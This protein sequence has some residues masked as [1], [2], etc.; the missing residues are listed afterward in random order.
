[1]LKMVGVITGLDSLAVNIGFGYISF[2]AVVRDQKMR[3]RMQL[4]QNAE[5]VWKHF[6]NDNNSVQKKM[7]GKKITIL[8]ED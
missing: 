7:S 4:Y 6:G 1:M 3:G 2:E 5:S 8:I